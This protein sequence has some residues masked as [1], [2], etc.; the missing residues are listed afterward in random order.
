M[1]ATGVSSAHGGQ[2]ELATMTIAFVRK[3]LSM[4]TQRPQMPVA[5]YAIVYYDIFVIASVLE[6]SVLW[7]S[8][9]RGTID[10]IGSRVRQ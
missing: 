1:S 9:F 3:Q 10:R 8:A 4:I 6:A 5:T 7:P 2:G